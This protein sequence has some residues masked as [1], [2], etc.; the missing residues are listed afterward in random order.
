MEYYDE[1]KFLAQEISDVFNRELEIQTRHLVE[2][3]KC[4]CV[5]GRDFYKHLK[6]LEKKECNRCLKL[7]ELRG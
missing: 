3:M 7:K 1:M 4:E 5:P 6:P 2:A